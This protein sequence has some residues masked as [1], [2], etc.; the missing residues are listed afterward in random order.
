M[1]KWE[2][3][4]MVG[5]LSLKNNILQPFSL[6]RSEFKKKSQ[7]NEQ[8]GKYMDLRSILKRKILC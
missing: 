3:V 5:V 7:K 4:H 8:S 6:N 1:G 2:Q